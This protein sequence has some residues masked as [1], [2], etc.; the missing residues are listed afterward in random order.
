MLSGSVKEARF[1]ATHWSVVLSA[2][3]SD[4]SIANPALQRLCTTYW[5]PL[6]SFARR[7]GKSP[8]D[9]SDLTQGFFARLLEKNWISDADAARGR[10]RAFLLTAFKRYISD[11]RDRDRSL[12]RGGGSIVFSIDASTEESRPALNLTTYETPES[13]FEYR[14]ATTLLDQTLKRLRDEFVLH[15]RE[16]IFE[17]LKDFLVEEPPSG[18]MKA[19]L[20]ELGLTEAAARMNLTRMRQ[21]YRQI[22]RSEIL[23]TVEAP[24]EVEEELQ[25]LYRILTRTH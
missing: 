17:G 15:G 24:N 2:N 21:R 4:S 12:K 3:C 16:K 20:G 8:E 18:G 1:S 14:W 23:Q 25:H 5:P 9:A 6:Y 13:A 7:L 10:F 22:L 11:N 19:R